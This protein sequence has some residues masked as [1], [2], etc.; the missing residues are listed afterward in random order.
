ML[1]ADRQL[2][3]FALGVCVVVS[4]LLSTTATVLKDRQDRAVEL[5]RKRNVLIA[6][7]VDMYG[8]DGR[9]LDGTQVV[10]IFTS[11]VSEVILDGATGEIIEGVTSAD[12]DPRELR[13][14]SRFMPLF[15]WVEDDAFTK[16]AFPIS[17]QGLWSTIYGFLALERDLATIAG[18]TFYRHGETPG[19]GGEIER[20]WFMSQFAG[21][22]LFKDGVPVDFEVVKG[23]AA[24][25]Y[26]EGSYKAVDGISGATITGNGVQNFVNSDFR[27]YNRYFERIRG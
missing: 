14:K 8:E 24:R 20:D 2:Y 7:G 18:I 13:D 11:R 23:G 17:G 1:K 27:N 12:I 22:Q 16:V 15:K 10:N 19:L 3:T 9:R 6:F 21:K 25:R 5:D 4:T 26:P